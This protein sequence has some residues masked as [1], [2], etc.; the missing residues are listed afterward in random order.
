MGWSITIAV[1]ALTIG[2][3]LG[4]LA[5]AARIS[6]NKFLK[7]IS[8]CY[9]EFIRGTPMLIQILFW[10]LGFPALAK[11]ITGSFVNLNAYVIGIVAIGINSGAYSCELFRSA[12]MAVDKGQWE[13][14]KTLGL[15]YSQMMR[16]IILPQAFKRLVA[17]MVNEFVTLIKDSSLISTIGA[18]ELTKSAQILGVNFYNPLPPLIVASIIYLI[19]TITISQIGKKIERKLAE[20]D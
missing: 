13:A 6:K 4:I 8:S 10:Y 19:L 20:S 2:T 9:V 17:P 7:A 11:M 14:S 3:I 15:S 16:F 18:I 5:A 1:S 12:I